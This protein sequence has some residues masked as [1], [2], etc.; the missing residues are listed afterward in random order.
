MLGKGRLVRRLLRLHHQKEDVHARRP[1]VNFPSAGRG[2]HWLTGAGRAPHHENTEAKA[3]V[4]AGSPAIG[5]ARPAG[6]WH[7]EDSRRTGPSRRLGEANGADGGNIVEE[8][9][10]CCGA[11]RGVGHG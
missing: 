3:M 7:V 1:P 11:K 5:Q 10:V 2:A 4:R 8:V 6:S 9:A